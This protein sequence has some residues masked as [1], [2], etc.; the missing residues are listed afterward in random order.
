SGATP[1]LSWDSAVGNPMPGSLQVMA[2]YSGPNQYVLVQKD[3]G[4]SNPQNWMGRKLHVRIRV[5]DGAF[6]G[7]AQV[8]IKT[9]AAF[10]SGGTYMTLAMNNNWQEVILDLTSPMSKGTSG[11]YDP[12]QVVQF[13]VELNTGSAG[14]GSTPVTFNVD[15]FSVDPPLPGSGDA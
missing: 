1:T 11:T 14:T 12:S 4:T 13:G 3:Y 10:G 5:T 8:L 9:G 15:S 7:G 2:P 6:K